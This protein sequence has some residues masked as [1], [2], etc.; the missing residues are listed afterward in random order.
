MLLEG[1]G[2]IEVVGK[3]SVKFLQGLLTNDVN[4]FH[5]DSQM[6]AL[7][8]MMLN[9]KGRV[10]YDLLLYKLQETS[11]I[12]GFLLECDLKA[13]DNIITTFKPYK[14]RSKVTFTDVSESFNSWCI[15][16]E[17]SLEG[18]QRT[19]KDSDGIILV[20]DP[21][22]RS[23]GARLVL[24]K[25]DL[26]TEYFSNVKEISDQGVYDRQRVSLGVGEGTKDLEPGVP[27]PLQYNTTEL[28]GGK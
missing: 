4:L 11:D 1:R 14:L 8:A 16:E 28:H 21:R 27:L 7:F 23:L 17:G 22:I 15:T 5:C 18:L 12:P 6:S 10:L 3:D 2:H 26:P 19:E 24:P 9:T 25:T 20:N 13:V